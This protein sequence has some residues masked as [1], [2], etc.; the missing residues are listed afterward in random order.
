M[1]LAA[2]LGGTKIHLALYAPD[3]SP[4]RPLREVRVASAD[5]RSFEHAAAGFLDRERHRPTLAVIGV[6]GPVAEGRAE[7]TNLSWVVD[8]RAVSA[9]LGGAHVVLLNDLEAMAWGL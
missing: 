8:A 1:I 3:G 9:A 2:D 7:A 5:Y 6:A 4:R